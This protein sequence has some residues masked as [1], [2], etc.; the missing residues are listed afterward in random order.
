MNEAVIILFGIAREVDPF[1]ETFERNILEP[2]RSNGITPHVVG[3]LNVPEWINNP[4]SNEQG[5]LD[6]PMA[7]FNRY[8]GVT[9]MAQSDDAI[10]EDFSAF[11][12]KGDR[13]NDGFRSL[14]NLL[15][16]QRSLKAG[17]EIALRSA[18]RLYIFIRPDLI[19]HD[20]FAPVVN[21][22]SASR[23]DAIW[24]PA[25][26]SFGGLNDRFAV[27][28]GPR[29][30][31]AYGRRIDLAHEFCA[32][33]VSGLHSERLVAYALGKSRIPLR[34]MSLRA[35]RIRLGGVLHNEDF[36]MRMRRKIRTKIR[37]F[38]NPKSFSN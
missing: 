33:G 7:I 2:I 24:I 1:V 16:Q 15:H 11:S 19:Y 12:K 3:C 29:S 38:L 32:L 28:S 17:T 23:K 5:R 4:R 30:A 35:S 21:A 25:W 8:P 13:W 6:A 27:A 20:S 26:Q 22:A 37:A 18:A 31:A 36:D 14:R 9:R 34:F 10:S